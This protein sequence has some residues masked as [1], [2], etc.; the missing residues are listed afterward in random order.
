MSKRCNPLITTAKTNTNDE[1]SFVLLCRIYPI[2]SALYLQ[3]PLPLPLVD[4]AQTAPTY[5]QSIQD[6]NALNYLFM[7]LKSPMIL[8]AVGAFFL[9][10]VLPKLTVS[11]INK[12]AAVA[13]KNASLTPHPSSSL[14]LHPSGLPRPRGTSTVQSESKGHERKDVSSSIWRLEESTD[15]RV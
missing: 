4:S 11:K 2:S 10:S 3:N 13:D 7:T 14:S 8:M 1:S 15:R 5:F 6:F 12:E 9:V